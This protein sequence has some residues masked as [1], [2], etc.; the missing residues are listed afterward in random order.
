M[1]ISWL[2]ELDKIEL[3]EETRKYA[4]VEEEYKKLF[5]GIVDYNSALCDDFDLLTKQL[6]QCIKSKTP[7]HVLYKEYD[8]YNDIDI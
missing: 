1:N 6:E 2:E 5:D 8:N 4:E 7:Y 3:D